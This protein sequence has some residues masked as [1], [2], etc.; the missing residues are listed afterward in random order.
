MGLALQPEVHCLMHE[1]LLVQLMVAAGMSVV[2]IHRSRTLALRLLY[3]HGIMQTSVV[4]MQ[5]ITMVVT[6]HDL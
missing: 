2:D 4:W 1:A 3:T 6:A 5:A